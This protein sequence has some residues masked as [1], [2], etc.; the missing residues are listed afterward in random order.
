MPSKTSKN[1]NQSCTTN[2]PK[3]D[4]NVVKVWWHFRLSERSC[5]KITGKIWLLITTH[6]SFEPPTPPKRGQ[7]QL[8][9][10]SKQLL[11]YRIPGSW[12][13]MPL[14]P[15][16]GLKGNQSQDT[17]WLEIAEIGTLLFEDFIS[18]FHQYLFLG[19]IL[20]FKSELNVQPCWIALYWW[21]E[22]KGWL[23]A[24]SAT[25]YDIVYDTT[26]SDIVMTLQLVTQTA[27]RK[28]TPPAVKFSPKF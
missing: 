27:G 14:W 22:K 17:S 10:P 6:I 28:T 4:Y 2:S 20:C 19:N 12:Q 13:S 18:L 23:A 7:K 9:E 15:T 8:N 16:P 11:K 21:R 24:Y 1:R 3:L 5:N 25:L 26:A